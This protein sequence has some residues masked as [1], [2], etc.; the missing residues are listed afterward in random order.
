MYAC[1]LLTFE[2]IDW[3]VKNFRAA[4]FS[5]SCACT[6]L[7]S[8]ESFESQSDHGHSNIRK[9][10]NEIEDQI[11]CDSC[12]LHPK[13]VSISFYVN[14]TVKYQLHIPILTTFHFNIFTTT[15]VCSP[16]LE[17]PIIARSDDFVVP[18][19]STHYS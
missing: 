2:V 10:L 18:Q 3:G 17:S 6:S 12:Y 16:H 4:N 7:E 13:P 1:G 19:I 14:I 8:W 11:A 9:R 15:T 5:T